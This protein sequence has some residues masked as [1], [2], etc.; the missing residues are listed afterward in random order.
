M[1]KY[2]DIAQVA[3]N[4]LEAWNDKEYQR[5]MDSVSDDFEVIEVATGESYRGAQGLLDEY[6]KWH[7]ALSDGWMD[8]RTVIS[9]GDQVAIETIVRGKHDGVF[10]MP[11]RDIPPS[12]NE[13]EFRMCTISVVRDGKEV[14]ERHYFDNESMLRQLGAA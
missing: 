4:I 5:G 14:E 3:V 6:T 1:P 8:I 7:T 13:I 11:D 10:A 12:G 2:D 9:S